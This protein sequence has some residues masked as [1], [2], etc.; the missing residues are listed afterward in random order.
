VNINP[1]DVR[2]ITK[3]N[4]DHHS[5]HSKPLKMD[6]QDLCEQTGNNNDKTTISETVPYEA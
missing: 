2:A 3:S 5:R 6:L 4:G 1:N